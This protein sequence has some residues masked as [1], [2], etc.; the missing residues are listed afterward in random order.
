MMQ[1]GGYGNSTDVIS[2]KYIVPPRG[3]GWTLSDEH[4][5]AVE[6]I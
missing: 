3:K 5:V 4:F 2:P 6:V 1:A